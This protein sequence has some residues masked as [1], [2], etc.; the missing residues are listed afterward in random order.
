MWYHNSTV[1]FI[2]LLYKLNNFSSPFTG[3]QSKSKNEGIEVVTISC[4]NKRYTAQDTTSHANRPV[5][6]ACHKPGGQ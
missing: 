1:L 4:N 6:K 5:T 3:S 2:P